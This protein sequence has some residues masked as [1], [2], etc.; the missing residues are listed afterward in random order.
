MSIAPI[1]RD[2]GFEFLRLRFKSRI[3][4]NIA[5]RWALRRGAVVGPQAARLHPGTTLAEMLRWAATSGTSSVRCLMV[6]EPALR[7]DFAGFL[8]H[9]NQVTFREMVQHYAARFEGCA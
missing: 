1:Q 6:F 5:L 2:A 9:A 8:D 4:E 7:M 3:E